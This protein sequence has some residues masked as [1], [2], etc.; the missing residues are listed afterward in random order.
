[1]HRYRDVHGCVGLGPALL[2]AAGAICCS[3]SWAEDRAGAPAAVDLERVVVTGTHIPQTDVEG[4]LPVQVI[5]REEIERSGVTTVEQ[6]LERVPA[7]FNAVN[8]AATVGN[9]TSPGLSSANLRGLGG[10]STLVLLNGRRLANYAFDGESVDLNSIPLAAIDRVEVLKDGASAIY[11]SDA[12]AGVINFI[13]RRDYAGAEISADI[14]ATQ[15]GGGNSGHVNAS[16]GTGDPGRDGY[17]VFATLSYQKDQ[18]LKALD[19]EFARTG[20]RPDQGMNHLIPST[21]PANIIDF[22]GGRALNP[23]FAAGCAPPSSL[24]IGP[25]PDDPDHFFD[26]ACGYDAAT[27]IDLLPEVERASAMVRGT[28][29]ADASVDVFAEVLLGRNRFDAQIAPFGAR[30]FTSFGDLLY[31][32]NGP[33]YPSAFAA[34]NGLSGDLPFSFRATELGPRLNS[35]TSDMQRYVMGAQGQVAGWDFDVAAVHSANSQQVAYSGSYVYLSKFVRALNT[36]LINPWGPSGPE[37]HALLASTAYSGTPQT[38]HGS[39]SLVNAFASR[40]ITRLAAGP[41]ALALGAEARRERLSYDW[42]PAVLAG[43]SPIDTAQQ[44]ASGSRNVLALFAELGV[45]IAS[46]LDAQLAARFDD[47]NDFGSTTN[48]KVALRW[49]PLRELLLRGSWGTGFRAPPLYSLYAPTSDNGLMTGVKDP[50]RCQ[51]TRSPQDCRGIVQLYS[52]GNPDL[53]AETS[54]QWTLG[55]VLEPA[56]G[57]SVGVDYWNIVQDGVIA[58]LAPE[59][60]LRYPDKFADRIIRG[61]VDPATPDLP[62]P[63]VAI[64]GSPINLGTTKTSGI[65]VFFKWAAPAQDWGQLRV[66]LQG[67]YVRQWETQIDGVN[68]LSML[69]S[70]V[71]GAPVPRW[72]S[73]L[74][75]DWSR[76]PWGATL[77]QVYSGGYVETRSAEDGRL[78]QVGAAASWDLQARY[79]GFEGWQLAAGIRNLFDAEPPLSDHGQ[80]F[81]TGYNP[82]AASPLGR[83]FYLRA[84][85]SFK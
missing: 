23:T 83:V 40:E 77:S 76:G 16:F 79:A 35:T 62:G 73:T 42:D 45:P 50:I 54:T 60:A 56:P 5:R 34:A 30:A 55:L 31:P 6:L 58:P 63:I 21:F 1:M 27:A 52:G 53:Q 71:Y 72:R 59:D 70:A 28:W 18:A 32:T 43:D 29:R 7:N 33:Y 3:G 78:W 4:A 65:D 66:G 13:L 8:A 11:G 15:H 41:L 68:W 67:T 20:Y 61:P 64:D 48:P 80:S 14:A 25:S 74:S 24:P 9:G 47:Y 46:G 85:H 44:S 82:Q 57:L 22:A 37:G 38:A 17:N 75:F 36:G 12:I 39:T 69:G 10:G 19:R 2:A 84:G 51:E 26:L 49:Q 81:Q